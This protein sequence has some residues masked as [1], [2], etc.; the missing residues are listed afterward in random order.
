MSRIATKIELCYFD[1]T[2]LRLLSLFYLLFLVILVRLKLNGKY[3]V[4]NENEWVDAT[5]YS[6][7]ISMRFKDC[8]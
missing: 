3:I 5:T 7:N 6:L 1:W 8:V 4:G 2:Y